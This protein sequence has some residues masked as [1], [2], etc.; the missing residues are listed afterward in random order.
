MKPGP[1]QEL[2]NRAFRIKPVAEF[3]DGLR[4]IEP[5]DL[6]DK[7]YT[8]E[9]PM[10]GP[11]AQLEKIGEF[12]CRIPATFWNETA[13]GPRIADVLPQIPAEYLDRASGFYIHYA[14]GEVDNGCALA[15]CEI[16]A[17]EL[18]DEVK[19]QPV[20]AWKRRY[21]EPFPEPEPPKEAFNAT[22][23][24]TLGEDIKR[25]K[26]LELKKPAGIKAP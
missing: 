2:I 6:Y 16:Y 17:G 21:T 20:I 11:K 5:L 4:F 25:M 26:P 1:D 3:E 13:L 15:L 12:A 8:M 22:A 24:T 14:S 18:P 19:Q 23:A 9:T 7:I 10:G